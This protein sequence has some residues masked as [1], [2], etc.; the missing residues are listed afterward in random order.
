VKLIFISPFP[1]ILTML[2]LILD[3]ELLEIIGRTLRMT[4]TSTFIA[5]CIGVPFGFFLERIKFPGKKIVITIN[6]TLMAT[7][8]VVAGLVVLIILRR[9]GPLGEWGMLFTLEA[10]I[11]AQ[12]LLIT[13]IICGMVHTSAS[14]NGPQIRAFGYTMGANRLQTQ[15]LL[16]RELSNEIFFAAVT[17]FGRA[18]SEVGAIMMVGGNI[19]H[20]TR[21]MTTA[22]ALDARRGFFDEALLLGAVLMIIA[23]I[24]QMTG[25]F[26]MR[27]E[28]RVDE[29]F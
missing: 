4:L 23:F 8:P 2:E 24:V 25:N 21:V 14:R 10:M 20:H 28:A 5:F 6:R 29:N 16:I 11:L 9:Q 3:R 12:V 18:M 19:R 17:G 7:P 13:P 26:L 27:R 22:I 1:H 15:V